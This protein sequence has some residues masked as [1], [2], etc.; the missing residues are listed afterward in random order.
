MTIIGSLVNYFVMLPLYGQLMGLDAIIGLG[1]AINPQVHDLFTFVIW[2]IAPF[3]V[4]K[5]VVISL[6][7]LPLYKKMGNIIKK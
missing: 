5:A 3:N 4:L 2:M 6:V 7:T 1:S